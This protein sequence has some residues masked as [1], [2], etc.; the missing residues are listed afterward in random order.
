MVVVADTLTEN[1]KK[2]KKNITNRHYTT[3]YNIYF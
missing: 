2:K 3:V 1:I